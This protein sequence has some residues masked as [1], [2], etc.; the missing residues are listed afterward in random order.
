VSGYDASR[1]RFRSGL[2]FAQRTTGDR[3]AV[4]RKSDQRRIYPRGDGRGG[5]VGLGLW[6]T[7]GVG[8]GV[9]FWTY[10]IVA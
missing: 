6:V 10:L 9:A 5:G 3:M 7:L 8:V 1:S 4:D 2:R